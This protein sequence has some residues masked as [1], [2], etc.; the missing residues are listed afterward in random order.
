M[1]KILGLVIL[2]S[3]GDGGIEFNAVKAFP[4]KETCETFM[5][6]QLP[7][8]PNG[9]KLVTRCIPAAKLDVTNT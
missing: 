8:V 5:K 9:Y 3:Q 1:L 6:E 2:L 7:P 4:D